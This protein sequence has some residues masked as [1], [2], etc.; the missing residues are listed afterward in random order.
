MLVEYDYRPLLRILRIMQVPVMTGVPGHD[1][2]I[3]SI[4]GYDG[5]IL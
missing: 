1:R 3:I 4:R 2:H 5:E